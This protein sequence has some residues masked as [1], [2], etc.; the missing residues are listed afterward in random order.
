MAVL[1][2]LALSVSSWLALRARNACSSSITSHGDQICVQAKSEA[3]HIA[4]G[5]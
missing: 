1:L 4:L 3:L 5:Q 2:K